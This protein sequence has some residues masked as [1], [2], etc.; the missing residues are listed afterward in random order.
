M[1]EVTNSWY[2]NADF[3]TFLLFIYSFLNNFPIISDFSFADFALSTTKKKS[4]GWFLPFLQLP[5]TS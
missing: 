5:L 3:F 2:A 1:F 4:V